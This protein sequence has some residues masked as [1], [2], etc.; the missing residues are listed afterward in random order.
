MTISVRL[1]I[2]MLFIQYLLKM[3]A[4]IYTADFYSDADRLLPYMYTGP[5]ADPN[6]ATKVYDL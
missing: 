3:K 6:E 1:L 4:Y 2:S 5:P